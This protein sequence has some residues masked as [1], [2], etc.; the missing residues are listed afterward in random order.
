MQVLRFGCFSLV[1]C[2][3]CFVSWDGRVRVAGK[4]CD[5]LERGLGIVGSGV[6]AFLWLVGLEQC[7]KDFV[8]VYGLFIV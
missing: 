1:V 7:I 2:A 3:Y 4:W 6:W 8:R 5:L